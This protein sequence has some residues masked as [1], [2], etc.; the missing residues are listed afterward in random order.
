MAAYEL[1]TLDRVPTFAAISEAVAGVRAAE[2]R[3][4]PASRTRCCAS[5][6][7]RWR[8]ARAPRSERRG[9]RV[10]RR[11]AA[12]RPSAIARTCGCRGVPRRG[13]R[14]AANRALRR[15]GRGSR[16]LIAK[17][18]EAAP[19][20]S[21]VEGAVSP[22]AILVRGAGDV[23][24]LPGAGSAWIVMEEGAQVIALAAGTQPG[25]RVLDA[26]A[27]HGNKAWL[28]AQEVEPGGAVDASDLHAHKLADL[29]A[30]PGDA[31][32]RA[33]YVADWTAP[34]T[35]PDDYNLVV[36][37][38]PCSGVGTLRRRPEKS[39]AVARPRT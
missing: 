5:S 15:E 36:V 11:L 8:R 3:R 13:P 17:L 29:R 30:G 23:R 24:R 38:A 2:T 6:R 26:C 28:F 21:I 10:G 4:R 25:E 12:R 31:R 20:A 32:V 22:R 16:R 34:T 37:D 35:V 18:A 39:D 14:A 1:A 27:G 7:M 9:R 19:G 33:T